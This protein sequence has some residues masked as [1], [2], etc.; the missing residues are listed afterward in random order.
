MFSSLRR[1]LTPITVKEALEL[2]QDVQVEGAST[3]KWYNTP[4]GI[5]LEVTGDI[6]VT[7]VTRDHIRQWQRQVETGVS[8]RTGR[9]RALT[10]QDSYKRALRRFFR[11]LIQMHHLPS[12]WNCLDVL[13]F[14]DL[15]DPEPQ[16]LSDEEVERLMNAARRTKRN[17]AMMHVLRASGVRV[18]GLRSMRVSKVEI[19]EQEAE[20][21]GDETEL[22]ELA[23]SLGLTH[24]I[25][26]RY[27]REL[28]GRFLVSE[29]GR[30]GK[31]S[32]RYAR[33]DH[34]ACVALLA[35]LDTRP[36]NAP[37]NLWLNKNGAPITES[38]LYQAFKAIA[39]RAG[40]D[41][42]PHTLRHTFSRKLL[43]M[44]VDYNTAARLTGHR[45]PMTLV[46]IYGPS[47]DE[48][49][50]EAYERFANASTD[51]S[52]PGYNEAQ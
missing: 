32:R 28:R 12:D 35:Y 38:G 34:D 20:L 43:G 15:P 4:I 52:E 6:P 24:L 23:R 17:F 40:V 2:V 21:A 16:S 25:Q 42:S 18:G 26:E 44:G 31:R 13:R 14:D 11:L 29:K 48:E 8:E 51:S 7:E 39:R 45:D 1:M 5:L 37:D 50:R 9:R 30:K 22:V 36:A 27:L 46:R 47:R 41:A 33:L 10:T 3:A 49:V 19:W